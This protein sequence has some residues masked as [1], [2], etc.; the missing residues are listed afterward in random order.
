MTKGIEIF[1]LKKKHLPKIKISKSIT[2]LKKVLQ[3]LRLFGNKVEFTQAAG[4]LD[5]FYS[6]HH[7]I[8]RTSSVR[9]P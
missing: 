6:L 8:K 2:E 4:G 3:I 5:I 9:A 1:K 7:E